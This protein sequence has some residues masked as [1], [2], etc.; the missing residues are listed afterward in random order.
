MKRT[1]FNEANG[2]GEFAQEVSFGARIP[3]RAFPSHQP[4]QFGNSLTTASK[5]A[6]HLAR[7]R[8]SLAQ[9]RALSPI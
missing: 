5:P 2:F 4:D 8:F 7:L 1:K 9:R 6:V 3:V